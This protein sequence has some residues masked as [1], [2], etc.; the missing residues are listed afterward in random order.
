M[1]KIQI[2]IA[3]CLLFQGCAKDLGNYNYTDINEVEFSNIEESYSVM[4]N[5]TPLNINPVLTMSEGVDPDS[6]RFEYQWVTVSV[7][8]ERDT[9]ATTRVL[10][11]VVTLT[12]GNYTLYLKVIDK[13]TEVQWTTYSYLSVGTIY[14]RGI[15]LMGEDDAGNADAQMIS[16]VIDTVLVENIL[17]NSGLPTLREPVGFIHTGIASSSYYDKCVKIWVMTKTGSYWLDRESMKGTTENHFSKI[18]YTTE[19]TADLSVVDV[20]P[21]VYNIRGNVSSG[22]YRAVVTSNGLLFNSGFGVNGGDFYIDPSNRLSTDYNTILHAFPFLFYPLKSFYGVVWYDT[23]NDRFLRVT[24]TGTT[25]NLLTDSPADIF[26]WNQGTTG[27]KLVYGENTY[28]KDGGHNSGNSFALMKDNQSKWFIYK[29]YAYG[30]SP[31]KVGF[32]Q[33]DLSV[34]TGFADATMYGFSSTRTLLFYVSGNKL[35][36]YDYDPGNERLY[37]FNLF[38]SDEISMI[39]FDTQIDPDANALYVATYNSASKGKLQRYL[40]NSDP[41]TVILTPDPVN[42]WSGLTKVKNM[43]WRGGK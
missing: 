38:G 9:I 18:V 16:M 12:P 5:S 19:P 39:K 10:N 41:N 14:T 27:R 17:K 33:I 29:M 7:T 43:S 35:Y 34:A 42:S 36:A 2:I 26:P 11:S 13:E 15:M 24:T 37:Q 31:K 23:D 25:S 21:Q 28:N 30:S 40:V 8:G 3:V 6:E 22:Y 20:A 4:I 1:K 32:Y